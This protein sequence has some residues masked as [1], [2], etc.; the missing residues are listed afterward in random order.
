MESDY[1]IFLDGN[2][3]GLLYHV[4]IYLVTIASLQDNKSGLLFLIIRHLLYAISTY[5]CR[6]ASAD[7]IHLLD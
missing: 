5:A 3:A 6:Y 7:L 2:L 4:E 1:S